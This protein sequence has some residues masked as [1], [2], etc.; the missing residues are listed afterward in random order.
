MRSSSGAQDELTVWTGWNALTDFGVVAG[1]SLGLFFLTVCVVADL[2]LVG[3]KTSAAD[4]LP[5]GLFHLM[6]VVLGLMVAV[7]VLDR[8]RSYVRIDDE[9]VS[10]RKW[11]GK[12]LAVPWRLVRALLVR[13]SV[14]YPGQSLTIRYEDAR[15]RVRRSNLLWEVWHQAGDLRG[16]PAGPIKD[17]I[18]RRRRFARH[19]Q[20]MKWYL[21]QEEVYEDEPS[22]DAPHDRRCASTRDGGHRRDFGNTGAP[23]GAATGEGPS[24]HRL[25]K[26]SAGY[27]AW[28]LFLSCNAILTSTA[29]TTARGNRESVYDTIGELSGGLVTEQH[30]WATVL[31]VP[32]LAC[33]VIAYRKGRTRLSMLSLGIAVVASCVT[34]FLMI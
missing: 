11:H 19:T 4:W 15:G 14:G 8:R 31:T 34:W 16:P 29:L 32:A 28:S 17:A 27:A 21:G 26:G 13:H 6:P 20:R 24:Q 9:G 22:A 1:T 2:G 5:A 10:C 33:A 23:Q 12:R 25:R 30:F 18:L 7:C 3:P